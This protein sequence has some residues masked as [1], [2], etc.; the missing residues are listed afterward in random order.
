V[1]VAVCVTVVLEM[2]RLAAAP[3]FLRFP[4]SWIIAVSGSAGH[5]SCVGDHS[6]KVL[7]VTMPVDSEDGERRTDQD[8]TGKRGSKH[9]LHYAVSCVSQLDQPC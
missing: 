8:A 5:G 4:H 3:H 6:L 2:R 1:T 9:T 7:G